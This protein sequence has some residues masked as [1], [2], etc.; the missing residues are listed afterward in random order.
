MRPGSGIPS[1]STAYAQAQCRCAQVIHIFVHSQQGNQSSC[2]AG[3]QA[4]AGQRAGCWRGHGSGPGAR[5][6]AGREVPG[7][8]RGSGPDADEI[9]P[10]PGPQMLAAELAG[11]PATATSVAYC[12]RS[13]HG[14]VGP[15]LDSRP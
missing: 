3:R 9:G 4:A 1:I 6:R 11:A 15:R 5:F 8:A 14:R 2:R 13:R 10:E 7:R 12:P